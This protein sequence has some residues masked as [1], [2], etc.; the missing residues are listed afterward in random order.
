[1][2]RSAMCGPLRHTPRSELP[3]AFESLLGFPLPSPYNSSRDA[4]VL[5]NRIVARSKKLHNVKELKPFLE[6]F[7]FAIDKEGEPVALSEAGH[8]AQ[9]THVRCRQSLWPWWHENKALMRK[10]DAEH[11]APAAKT[12]TVLLRYD[13]GEE[14]TIM[15]PIQPSRLSQKRFNEVANGLMGA[16]D[17]RVFEPGTGYAF[18]S[19]V[20]HCFDPLVSYSHC[21]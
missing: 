19:F 6:T 13:T 5:R 3:A 16:L 4:V 10:Y 8:T 20:F 11:Y 1:M 17:S 12:P 7:A 18:H 14:V 21:L 2:A 9:C 15:A